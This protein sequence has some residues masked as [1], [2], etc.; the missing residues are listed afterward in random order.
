MNRE[1][2]TR[3]ATRSRSRRR[4]AGSTA[5]P[6]IPAFP[7]VGT[8]SRT[9]RRL[10]WAARLFATLLLGVL[11]LTLL[12]AT[13]VARA[14]QEAGADPAGSHLADAGAA[15]SDAAL[16]P[17][18]IPVPP[19]PFADNP[20]PEACGI[21]QP[22]GSDNAAYA[23]GWYGGERVQ[24]PVLLYDSHLRR[25]VVAVVPDGHPITLLLSQVNPELNY[26][27][28]RAEVDGEAV[29][30]WLPAPFVRREPPGG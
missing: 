18:A 13:T 19:L 25:A 24:D 22:V 23:H 12:L 11:P 3:P 1:A 7:N 21:P 28:V 29:Q 4:A 30:G 14:A 10:P 26:F 20:D 6:A 5:V 15:G 17:G 2:G 27:L 8:A 16:D 9:R